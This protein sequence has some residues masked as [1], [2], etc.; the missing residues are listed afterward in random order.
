M[1]VE[2]K[3][4]TASILSLIGGIFILIGG[5]SII[6]LL[7][8][9]STGM[10]SGMMGGMMGSGMMTSMMGNGMMGEGMMGNGMMGEGM[11]AAYAS[12]YYLLQ[13]LG[14]FVMI[15]GIIVIIGAI[16]LQS[17]P[18]QNTL[19]GM[20]ILIFSVLSIIGGS[21][22]LLS[23]LLLGAIGGALAISWKPR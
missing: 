16:M 13:S 18:Q 1:S 19:W 20:I 22:I 21:G 9:G 3:P 4:T 11:M 17:K 12:Y 6:T 5:I 15:A 8:I 14:I 2:D 23:G 7:S 10:M